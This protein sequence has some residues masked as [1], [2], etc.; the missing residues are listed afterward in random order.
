MI[1]RNLLLEK[2]QEKYEFN[3]RCSRVLFEQEEC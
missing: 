2:T 3:G 1:C